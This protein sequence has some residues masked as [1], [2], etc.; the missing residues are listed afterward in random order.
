V[1]LGTDETNLA[2][3]IQ[4][5]AG[6]KTRV[7][8]LQGAF[9]TICRRDTIV[10][11]SPEAEPDSAQKTDSRSLRLPTNNAR[12]AV[13][14]RFCSS[15]MAPY[16]RNLPK[17]TDL[18]GLYCSNGQQTSKILARVLLKALSVELTGAKPS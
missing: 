1:I 12:N 16:R 5:P 10:V 4:P 11:Y 13:V 18:A 15:D 17:K 3:E 2:A 6:K 14:Q 8:R 7:C 9:T